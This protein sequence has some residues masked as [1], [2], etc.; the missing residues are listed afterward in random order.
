MMDPLYS[1]IATLVSPCSFL[2][3]RENKQ[4]SREEIGRQEGEFE[5]A[6]DITREE[7]QVIK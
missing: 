6:I 2:L 4:E 3:F 5:E 1:A 7:R